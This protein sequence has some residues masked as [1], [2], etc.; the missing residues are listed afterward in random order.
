MDLAGETYYY[1]NNSEELGGEGGLSRIEPPSYQITVYIP[2]EVPSWYKKGIM[3]QIFVDRFYNGSENQEVL[4]PK[5]KSLIHGN[6]NDSPFY[7]KDEKGHISRWTFFGG[8][9]LGVIKRLPY[10]QELGITIIYF[11]PIFEAASNHKYDTGDYHKIDPMFGDEETFEALVREAGKLGI[12]VILDGVFSH[13]GSDS[14]Y[15]NK[16]GN[17]PSIGAFQTPESPYYNWYRFNEDKEK[18]ECWWGVEDLPNVEEMEPS[19]RDF[20]YG[21]PDSVIG[22]WMTKGVKGWRLDVVDELPDEF[23]KELRSSMKDNDSESVL[24]GEVWEDA[25]RKESYGKRREY[26]WGEELDSTMNYPWRIII[27]EF[28]LGKVNS[29]VV[30]HRLMSLY[31]NYPLENFKAA[32]NLIG[33]HDRVRILTLLGGAPNEDNLSYQ[34]REEYRLSPGAR[35]MAVK[36]L[37]LI[38]LIQMT[39]LGVPCI[40]YGDEAGMEGYADPFNRGPYP[41]GREDKEIQE[42]YKRILRLRKEYGVFTQ[43]KFRSFWSGEDVYGYILSGE[44]EE[45]T[46]FVNRS[47]TEE[48]EVDITPSIFSSS[49]EKPMIDRLLSLDLLTGEKL[50]ESNLVEEDEKLSFTMKVKPL[51][52]KVIYSAWKTPPSKTLE[53][54][55]GI[56]LHL[57][58]LPSPWGIG[59]MGEEARRF[60][61]FLSVSGQRL[62]QIL[63]LNPPGAGHSPYQSSSV[64]AGNTL[65]ISIETLI[66][67]KLVTEEEARSELVNIQGHN[68]DNSRASFSLT[69]ESKEKLFRKAF[70]NFNIRQDK[71]EEY[72]AFQQ[73]NKVW[74][75]DYC[76]YVVLKNDFNQLPWYEWEKPIALREETI[77][78]A[79]RADLSEEIEYQKFLQYIFFGQWLNLKKYANSKGILIIGDLPIYVAG[80]SSDSWVNKEIFELDAEGKTHKAAGVPPDYFSETGQLWGNPIYDWKRSADDGYRW[81]KAR[82]KHELTMADYIRLDHFRGFEAYWEIMASE[83]TAVNGRWLKGPGKRFFETMTDEFGSLPFIAEDLGFITPEVDNLRNIFAF[84]GM[85]VLQF[86]PAEQEKKSENTVYYTGTHD[87]DTLIGWYK[88]NNMQTYEL[89]EEMRAKICLDYIAQVYQSK[90]AWVIVPLQDILFLDSDARM[91]TPGTICGNWEW[92]MERG[93]LSESTSQWLRELAKEYERMV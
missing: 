59:D 2:T 78:A 31:E 24:I 90:C 14:I 48:I 56:L 52:G 17:Y 73:E 68:I 42:W 19:Y 45:I 70:A 28:I 27:L 29:S 50:M 61:D 25:S 46:V 38:S 41:W 91:N 66:E 93:T 92:R 9:L 62:W 60:V 85:R 63:P 26:L 11:N 44:E 57:T 23:V 77:L 4:N 35:M 58:S 82:I 1:G 71:R 8:N 21:G 54:S 6:W 65:L 47:L 72:L 88:E 83:S 86:D 36:R 20:I 80:D 3:Y 76:L 7:I 67:D 43:G 18:Y 33:S 5:N 30:H 40:Y 39:F 75:D 49:K 16:Y 89:T 87:N 15:F 37:K 51:E 69:Q 84:P 10:L 81:W 64:F 22:H 12:H 32:M 55:S 34:D 13:T 74:L 53:R 79:L